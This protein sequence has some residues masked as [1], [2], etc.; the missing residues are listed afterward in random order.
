[1]K[2]TNVTI[3]KI[4][5]TGKSCL[6]QFK[7][8]SRQIGYTFGWAATQEDDEVDMSLPDFEYQGLENAGPRADGSPSTYEDGTPVQLIKF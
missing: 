4:S 6:L 7:A 8:H 1:V 5:K 3:N 2:A